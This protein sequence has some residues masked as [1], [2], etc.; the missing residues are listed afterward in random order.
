MDRYGLVQRLEKIQKKVTVMQH[1][2][3][4]KKS[5]P[6][7]SKKHDHASRIIISIQQ[8]Y[9]NEKPNT[10]LGDLLQEAMQSE[11]FQFST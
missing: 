6:N 7:T 11:A 10:R 8:L 3:Y 4:L 5:N 9:F 1:V 2:K